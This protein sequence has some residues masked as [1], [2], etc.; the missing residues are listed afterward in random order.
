MTRH[1]LDLLF[2]Q[3]RP[4]LT[5]IRYVADCKGQSPWPMLGWSL[6]RALH[7][8]PYDVRYKSLIGEQALNSLVGISGPTG[9]GKTISANL[10]EEHLIFPDNNPEKIFTKTWA[11]RTP[12]GSG[13]AMPDFYVEAAP[14]DK[15]EEEA[16]FFSHHR[17]RLSETHVWKHPNHA[18][19]F[20]FDEG[21]KLESLNSRQGSTVTEYMKEGWSGSEFG[22]TLASGRGI[23][24]PKNS[25]RFACVINTQPKRSGALFTD[26]AIAGGLQ[27]RFLWFD[28]TADINRHLVT[29][30]DVDPVYI[31]HID[32]SGVKHIRALAS[33]NLAH[34]QHH[35]N[36]LDGHVTD[37]ESHI[38]LTKAKVAV[39]LAVLD[40]RVEL[41]DEDWQLAEVIIQ[42]TNETRSTIQEVLKEEYRRSVISDG[43]RAAVKVGFSEE[44]RNRVRVETVAAALLRWRER[45]GKTKGG[46]SALSK[47]QRESYEEA[48]E[49]LRLHPEWRPPE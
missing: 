33:M 5:Q 47:L 26:E 45:E 4:Y 29:Y 8:V 25:Y 17:D 38:L 21:G 46:K 10:V 24:L 19:V 9:A 30:E 36:A 28:V 22:R 49:F 42:H 31:P 13:E 11:G 48:D 3:S 18:A 15:D 44:E 1:N 41:N 40:G 20:F 27:G 39:G 16:V 6:I 7:T 43:K 32:W 23:I 14:L 12:P 34:Q 37:T 2:W 35:W